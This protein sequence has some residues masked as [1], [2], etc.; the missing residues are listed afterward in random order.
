MAKAALAGTS[1]T[2]TGA[3]PDLMSGITALLGGSGSSGLTSL[4]QTFHDKGLGDIVSSWVSTGANLP[5][6]A[7]Q[8]HNALGADRL[9]DFAT[10]AGIA[11]ETAGSTLASLLPNVIDKLTPNGK[12]P[13]E[14]LASQLLGMFKSGTGS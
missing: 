1:G 12:I 2:A 5:V 9:R 14:G 13:E 3:E 11:P 10:K 6:S 7:D 8:V 4:V